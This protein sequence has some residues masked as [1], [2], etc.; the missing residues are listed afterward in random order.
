MTALLTP[1][2]PLVPTPFVAV[3]VNVYSTPFV[4]PWIVIGSPVLL[5][6]WPP[7]EA[8]AV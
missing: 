3:T 1:E 4:R 5:P 6:D 2:S 7:G 8:V